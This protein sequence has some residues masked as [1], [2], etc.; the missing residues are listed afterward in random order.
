MSH[1]RDL[2][3]AVKGLMLSCGLS[4]KAAASLAG[5][6]YLTVRD[7]RE[8]KRHGKVPPNPAVRKALAD[9]LQKCR[10]AESQ[11]LVALGREHAPSANVPAATEAKP[12]DTRTAGSHS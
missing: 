5:V 7:W 1:P 3:A 2:V 10:H 12:G 8:G 11:T 9:A 6:P 4:A